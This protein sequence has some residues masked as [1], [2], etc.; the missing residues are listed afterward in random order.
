MTGTLLDTIVYAFRDL[1]N[2]QN[3][4]L[5]Y[6]YVWGVILCEGRHTVTGIYLAGQPASRYWSLVK[7]LSRGRWEEIPL[8]QRLIGLLVDYLPDWVY[9]YDHTHAIKTGKKQWGLHFFRNHRYRK[10]NTNQSKFHWGH[11]FAA[12]GIVGLDGLLTRLF[13]VWVRL[14]DPHALGTSAL[15]AFESIV[16]VIP[17]GLII[18]DRGFNNR[19]YFNVLLKQGHHLLCRARKNGAF[20]YRPLPSQQPHRGRKRIYGRRV[21]FQQWTYTPIA[22]PGF[23]QPLW[24]AHHIVRTRMCPQ[25]VRLVVV[26]T[27]PPKRRPYRYFLVYTTDVTLP[28]ETIIRYYQVRWGFE[29]N[30]RDTKEELGFDHYQVRSPRSI[31]RSVL[32]SFVAASLTQLVAWPAFEQ[33]HAQTFPSL[34][35]GLAQMGIHWYHPRRWTLGLLLRYLR[36]QKRRQLFSA[37]NADEQNHEKKTQPYAIAAG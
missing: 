18:F 8:V 17:A 33:K 32:L 30:M 26:R 9:V 29:T 12:L 31:E 28:V 11:Q 2:S 5:F 16:S 23:E 27:P 10:G 34:E 24:V 1:F 14:L 3:F 22:V 4:A 15:A 6:A 7:F 13:P 35:Q 20:F 36:G 19:K 25:P 37:S 21:H